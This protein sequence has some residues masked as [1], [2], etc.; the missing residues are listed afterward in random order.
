MRPQAHFICLWAAIALCRSRRPRNTAR[1]DGEWRSYGGDAGSTKYSPLDQITR[2][3][4]GDL[5]IA[6]RWVT[7]DAQFD[8]EQLRADNSNLEIANDTSNVSI[9]GLKATPLMVNGVLYLTTPLSQVAAIDAASGETPLGVRPKE[10][11]VGHS[12]HGA[13]VQPPRAGLLDRW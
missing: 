4:V 7:A 6:W 2:D 3:N 1:T 12:D 10:L 9:N 11:C 8:V 13:R 5:R